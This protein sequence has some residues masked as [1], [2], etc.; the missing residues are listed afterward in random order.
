MLCHVLHILMKP[1]CND[2]WN[3]WWDPKHVQ[4]DATWQW[5]VWGKQHIMLHDTLHDHLSCQCSACLRCVRWRIKPSCCIFPAPHPANQQL[6]VTREVIVPRIK[7]GRREN[8]GFDFQHFMYTMNHKK[9][10]GYLSSQLWKILMDFYNF[11]IV[12]SRIN[13]VHMYEKCPPH[14]LR[15]ATL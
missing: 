6:S 8:S 2:N 12:V 15:F 13:F 14:H 4:T 10:A 7:D 1:A 5:M 9:V 3:V 11:C